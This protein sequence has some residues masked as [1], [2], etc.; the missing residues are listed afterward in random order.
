MFRNGKILIFSPLFE[1]NW[2]NYLL[3]VNDITNDFRKWAQ[4][5]QTNFGYGGW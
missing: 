5:A 2:T 1:E 3:L 4:R